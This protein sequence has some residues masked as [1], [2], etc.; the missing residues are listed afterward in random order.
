MVAVFVI[1]ATF[2]CAYCMCF[3]FFS[4]FF[5]FCYRSNR[6]PSMY[7]YFV[8]CVSHIFFA[9]TIHFPLRVRSKIEFSFSHTSLWL[10]GKTMAIE[11]TPEIKYKMIHFFHLMQRQLMLS[12]FQ[13]R[14][15]KMPKRKME[16]EKKRKQLTKR[17]TTNT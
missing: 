3:L 1:V 12:L 9:R 14:V 17:Q 6:D 2:L 15:A 7:Y 16:Y 4:A 10:H 8:L 5:G 13:Q 11:P